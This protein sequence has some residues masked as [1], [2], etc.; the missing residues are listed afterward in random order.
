MH[1]RC[2]ILTKDHGEPSSHNSAKAG[3]D[4]RQKPIPVS[5]QRGIDFM[6]Q[7]RKATLCVKDSLQGSSLPL[8]ES[9]I[10]VRTNHANAIMRGWVI[11]MGSNLS[12]S[13][14]ANSVSQPIP[15]AAVASGVSNSGMLRF[16]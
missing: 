16:G 8:A 15:V 2:S 12:R 6:R 10:W 14:S 4:V 7:L 1:H 13:A 9:D 5:T 3:Q 11:F